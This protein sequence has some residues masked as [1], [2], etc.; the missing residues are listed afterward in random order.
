[1]THRD[2]QIQVE[3][4]L[5]QTDKDYRL[6][7]KLDTDTLFSYINIGIDKFVKTRVFGTNPKQKSF[8][9][10]QKRIDDLRTLVTTVEL[11][12]KNSTVYKNAYQVELPEDYLY[13]VGEDVYITSY[14]KCWKIIDG[15]PEVKI[16]DVLECTQE[17]IT[18]RLNNSLSDYHLHNNTARPLRLV[19][20]NTIVLFTDGKYTIPKFRLT[21]IRRPLHI[22]EKLDLVSTGGG[23]GGGIINRPNL[24]GG[25]IQITPSTQFRTVHIDSVKDLLIEYSDLPEHT[26]QEIINLTVQYILANTGNPII[27]SFSSEVNNME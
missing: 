16:V 24:G 15:S 8:E 19:V 17:N 21:Y 5:W 2:I 10:D 13:A 18:S 27:N 20:D 26:L 11:K 22:D 7:K 1:M 3:R 25:I 4:L 23:I 12:P 6:A 14:D 9:Q